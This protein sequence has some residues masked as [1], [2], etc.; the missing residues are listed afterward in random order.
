MPRSGKGN[1]VRFPTRRDRI[2]ERLMHPLELETLVAVESDV[3][4]RYFDLDWVH[5]PTVPFSIRRSRVRIIG[6]QWCPET[7]K[8]EYTGML[9][10]EGTTSSLF[11]ADEIRRG[12]KEIKFWP[13]EI[14]AVLS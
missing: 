10:I 4:K 8:Y 3:M 1:V 13:W 5:G 11:T 14:T 6:W 9:L 2:A 12:E 7:S